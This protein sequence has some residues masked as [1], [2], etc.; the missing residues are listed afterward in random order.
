MSLYKDKEIPEIW[1]LKHRNDNFSYNAFDYESNL[2]NKSLSSFMFN[3]QNMSDFIGNIT[4]MMVLFFD[5]VNIIRNFKNYLV[6]KYY[7]QHIN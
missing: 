3:N 7:N 5:Q 2:M 4:P 1:D 6:D